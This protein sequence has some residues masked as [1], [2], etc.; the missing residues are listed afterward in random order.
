[1]PARFDFSPQGRAKLV[2]VTTLG[3]VV[4]IGIS[5][6]ATSFI[7]PYLPSETSNL[8]WG[9]AVVVPLLTAGLVF[10][11]FANKLRQLAIAHHKLALIASQDSLTTCLNRGAFM[12]LVDAY[13]S[14]VNA[15]QPVDGAMLIVDADH[16][17]D[18]NDRFG[19]ASGDEAL[20]LIAS[21]LK[22]AVRPNDLVGRIG[23]EEFAVFLA[24][25][26]S[27]QAIAVAERIRQAIHNSSFDASGV[28][29][30]LSVSVGAAVFTGP[31]TS[32]ALFQSADSF[33]YEAKHG[34]RNRVAFGPV[35]Q[36]TAA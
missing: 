34:G 27:T 22:V 33:L 36:A 19:H 8:S 9:M 14:Q 6:Y 2:L 35:G 31:V 16:F 15:A 28:P 24:R 17:K 29:A 23:G 12:T 21:T 11:F 25:A 4:V 26:D 30:R 32:A 20:R 10:Y 18:I 1:M 5:L 13:L 7:A 3:L